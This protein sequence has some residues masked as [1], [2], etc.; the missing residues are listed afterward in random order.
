MLQ[1]TDKGLMK[2][3][4]RLYKLFVLERRALTKLP[5]LMVYPERQV[6]GKGQAWEQ[7]WFQT[8]LTADEEE[9]LAQSLVKSAEIGVGK[10][11]RE[12]FSIVQRVLT[13]KGKSLDHF[14]GE[15][16]WT[17]FTERHP[18]FSLR[19]SDPLSRVYA[20]P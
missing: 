12:V 19:A 3:W 14:N 1:S 4:P 10:T 2:K 15:G 9:E 5:E 8:L 16:W 7:V 6:V 20:M 18:K 13:K 11:K 17:G